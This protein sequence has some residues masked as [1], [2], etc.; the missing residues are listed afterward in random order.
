MTWECFSKPLIAGIVSQ[1]AS[2]F[3]MMVVFRR[4]TTCCVLS[5]FF[6]IVIQSGEVQNTTEFQIDARRKV[7][8]KLEFGILDLMTNDLP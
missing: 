7:N 5:F 3:V 6:S 1:Q 2:L 8:E 4:C